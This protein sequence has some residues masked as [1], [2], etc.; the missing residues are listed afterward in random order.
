MVSMGLGQSVLFKLRRRAT[1]NSPSEVRLGHGDLSV[2]D[3]PPQLEYEHS[4]SSELSGLR[5]N[6][7]YIPVFFELRKWKWP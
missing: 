7:T 4:T 1:R 3:G 6:V 5:V 2:L